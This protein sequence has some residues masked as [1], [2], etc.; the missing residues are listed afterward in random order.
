MRRLVVCLILVAACTKKNPSASC[1]DG[2]C[3]DP[4]FPFCDVDGVIGGEPNSCIAVSC[5]TGEFGA[6]DGDNVLTCNAAGNGYD[7]NPCGTGCS[8]DQM[9]CAGCTPNTTRCVGSSVETCDANG[10]V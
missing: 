8:A 3:S 4:N 9:G 2:V 1:T 10:K 7:T 6:C 5:T